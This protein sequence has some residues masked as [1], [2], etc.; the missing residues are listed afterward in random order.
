[1]ADKKVGIVAD[2]TAC[3]PSE[4][5]KELGIQVVPVDLVFE[6][7]V[8]RDGLDSNYEE[9]YALLKSARR[10]PTTS[11]P[12]PSS[13]LEAMREAGKGR[14]GVLCI[15]V[16]SKVSAMYESARL[17]MEMA[18]GSMPG[19][20]VTVLDSGTAAM[21]QGFVALEAARKA[22]QG[23]S[24]AEVET[25]A[26]QVSAKANIVA[27]LD[28]LYY[29]AKGGRIP[30]AAAWI[31]SVLS[32]K[33]ILEFRQGEVRLVERART[34]RRALGR[35][36]DI[37]EERLGNRPVHVAV[38]HANAIEEAQIL[39]EKIRARWQCRELYI[40]PFTPVM[41]AHLGPG[42]VGVA[43]YPD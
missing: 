40:T 11:A 42:L 27:M 31:G 23:V 34:R 18:Q 24:L 38:V 13:Y 15:T 33:P 2:S 4:L 29:L 28:T 16:S 35:L 21:A 17:A 10:L 20:Q 26:R 43:F 41:G 36:L 7:K 12:S 14:E 22:A 1:M 8:Y 30:R 25:A 37:V 9:F 19:L 3:L 39:K 6:G 32:I 5:A